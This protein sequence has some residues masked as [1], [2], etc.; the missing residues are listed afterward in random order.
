MFF[1]AAAAVVVTNGEEKS[2]HKCTIFTMYTCE[3]SI[4]HGSMCLSFKILTV[5]FISRMEFKTNQ[6]ETR[7]YEAEGRK[8]GGDARETVESH[9]EMEQLQRAIFISI[10]CYYRIGSRRLHVFNWIIECSNEIK[11]TIRAAVFSIT[12][13]YEPCVPMYQMYQAYHFRMKKNLI[14]QNGVCAKSSG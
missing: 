12:M 2:Q 9:R 11:L 6:I 4:F 1:P 3:K 7:A 13:R 10:P 8:E 5:M 14:Q